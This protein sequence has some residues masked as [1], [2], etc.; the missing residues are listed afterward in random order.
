[1]ARER[2]GARRTRSCRFLISRFQKRL[3][4]HVADRLRARAALFLY[5]ALTFA[6]SRLAVRNALMRA[7][8]AG[9]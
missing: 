1:V 4:D 2:L 5:I 7:G 3:R 9:A 6:S 8:S